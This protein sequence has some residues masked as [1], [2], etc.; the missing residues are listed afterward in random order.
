M[1][2]VAFYQGVF[3]P[4]HDGTMTVMSRM[5]EAMTRARIDHLVFTPLPPTPEN[6]MDT[7]VVPVRA[8]AFPAYKDYAVAVPQRDRV[9]KRLDEYAPNLVQLGTPDLG[10]RCVLQW[11]Q[12]RG[13]P[14]VGAYHTHFPTY[15][16]Y[17][18]LPFAERTLWRYFR[19]F[20]NSCARTLVPSPP[21]MQELRREGIDRLVLWPRGVDAAAFNPTHRD[22]DFR[23]K[24]GVP[25]DGVVFAYVGRFVSEKNVEAVAEAW[26]AVRER[27][28]RARFL[29]IGDG[30]RREL[31]RKLTPD[32]HFTGYI[33]GAELSRAYASADALVFCSRTETFGNVILEAMASGLA[34]VTL[35][36]TALAH[37]VDAA[38]GGIAVAS[39]TAAEIGAAMVQ[40]HDD[41]ELRR[42]LA[43]NAL[44][45]AKTQT[46]EAIFRDQFAVY[47][48]VLGERGK[49][50][51]V[52]GN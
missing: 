46:W 20:Y 41:A 48:E 45:Y 51:L 36:G 9:W 22:E 32:A 38:R 21:I 18:K 27:C 30:P 40:L 24:L 50:E 52:S 37:H 3:R 15:L 1:L 25:E 34:V 7:P 47:V 12:A 5:V 31:I 39:A 10:G 16:R 49:A 28:P 44:A 6:P 35:A 11:A 29:W 8:F 13:V 26:A 2:K 42:T 17:Y 19:W 23:R 33:T 4:H 43:A 14:A